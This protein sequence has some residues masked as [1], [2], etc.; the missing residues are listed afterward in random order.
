MRSLEKMTEEGRECKIE[1][2]E[3][4]KRRVRKTKGRIEFKMKT[5]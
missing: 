5:E 2:G 3:E 4:D 1:G